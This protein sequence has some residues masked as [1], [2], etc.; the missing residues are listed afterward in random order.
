MRIMNVLKFWNLMF[1]YRPQ[2]IRDCEMDWHG[3]MAVWYIW[4]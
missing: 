4:G 2:L 3:S 1:G